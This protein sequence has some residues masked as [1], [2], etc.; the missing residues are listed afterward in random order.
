MTTALAPLWGGLSGLITPSRSTATSE[1]AKRI[2][3][4]RE[5][6]RSHLLASY[7]LRN[8]AERTL[9]EL[10]EVRAEASQRGWNGHDAL[11]LNPSAYVF[12]RTFLNALPTTAPLP[13]VSADPDGEVALD[14]IFGERKALSVSISSTGRCTFAWMQGQSTCRGTDWIEDEIPASIVYALGRLVQ[15]AATRQAR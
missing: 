4:M 14:W 5:E 2:V 7:V 8:T 10:D 11:P 6:I 15:D 12:A 3:K 13:E 9:I 1:P